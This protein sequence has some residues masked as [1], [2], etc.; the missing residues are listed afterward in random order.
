MLIGPSVRFTKVKESV[1][2]QQKIPKECSRRNMFIFID[3]QVKE[4]C[5]K[6]AFMMHL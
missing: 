5:Y 2:D 6:A 4:Y 3:N 1:F